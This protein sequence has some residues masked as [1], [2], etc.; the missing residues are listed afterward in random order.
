[1]GIIFLPTNIRLPTL[2]DDL[3]ADYVAGKVDVV[4]FEDGVDHLLRTGTATDVAPWHGMQTSRE[5]R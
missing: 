5:W 4:A 2:L 1:M 3:R